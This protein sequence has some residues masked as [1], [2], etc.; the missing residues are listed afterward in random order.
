MKATVYYNKAILKAALSAYLKYIFL[1]HFIFP[2]ILGIALIFFSFYAPLGL[3]AFIVVTAFLGSSVLAFAYWMRVERTFRIL[4]T[5]DQGRV[6]F[7]IDEDSLSMSP[8]MGT[9]WV[10]WKVFSEVLETPGAFLVLYAN[11]HGFI[12]F[13]KDQISSEFIS[14]IKMRMKTNKAS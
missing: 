6:E 2:T 1:K 12:T 13:P 11:H 4:S 3:Q 10:S 9:S 7:S 14:E 8:E 5:L